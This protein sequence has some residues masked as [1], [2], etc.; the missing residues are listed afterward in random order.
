MKLRLG[1]RRPLS[2]KPTRLALNWMTSA[3]RSM[4]ILAI[5]R[6]LRSSA[7]KRTRGF[8]EGSGSENTDISAPSGGGGTLLRQHRKHSSTTKCPG[9]VRGVSI[10][11]VAGR[12]HA[13]KRQGMS[14]GRQEGSLMHIEKSLP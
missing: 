6:C 4:E 10:P 7:P 9:D 2:M 5:F 11:N 3:R 14:A 12:G 1:V 13:V 8:I